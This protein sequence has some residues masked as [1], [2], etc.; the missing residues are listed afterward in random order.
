MK[1]VYLFYL[2][3]ECSIRRQE[4]HTVLPAQ[5]SHPSLP[6]GKLAML[7]CVLKRATVARG[8]SSSVHT[9]MG[10]PCTRLSGIEMYDHSS[11]PSTAH[12]CPTW[13]GANSLL[14]ARPFGVG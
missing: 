7:T 2:Y 12:D 6:M 14:K 9:H 1:D 8:K 3:T 5:Q 10:L 13:V 4:M 11:C